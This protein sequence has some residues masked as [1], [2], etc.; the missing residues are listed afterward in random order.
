MRT[1]SVLPD[2]VEARATTADCVITGSS[3]VEAL[4][5]NERFD[6][7]VGRCFMLCSVGTAIATAG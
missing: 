2:R 7:K 4:K 1:R 3:H 6:L 5:L